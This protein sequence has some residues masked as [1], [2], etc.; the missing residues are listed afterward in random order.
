[1]IRALLCRK[2]LVSLKT[3]VLFSIAAALDAEVA[4]ACTEKLAFLFLSHNKSPQ[5]DSAVMYGEFHGGP[6]LGP[7]MPRVSNIMYIQFEFMLMLLLFIDYLWEKPYWH[8]SMFVSG[9]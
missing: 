1:M 7:M 6:Q 8:P 9:G 2:T 4:Q 5:Y 3:D